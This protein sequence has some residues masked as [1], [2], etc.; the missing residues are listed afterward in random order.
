ME[1]LGLVLRSGYTTNL[2]D[3]SA[4]IE[5]AQANFVPFGELVHSFT[6]QARPSPEVSGKSNGH[7]SPCNALHESKTYEIYSCDV[8]V[9]HFKDYLVKMETFIYWFIDAASFVE[10][11][12]ERWKFF[13]L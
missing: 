3:F 12:D 2:D 11:D 5:K 10:T 4:K 13:V 1:K 8:T 6:V 7:G 9:P